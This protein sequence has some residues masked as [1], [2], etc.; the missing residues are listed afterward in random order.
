MK[1]DLKMEIMLNFLDD[2]RNSVSEKLTISNSQIVYLEHTQNTQLMF[3]YI[4]VNFNIGKSEHKL[5]TYISPEF[6]TAKIIYKHQNTIKSYDCFVISFI[7]TTK[8]DDELYDTNQLTYDIKAKMIGFDPNKLRLFMKDEDDYNSSYSDNSLHLL[9]KVFKN[10]E[11]DFHKDITT[12][13]YMIWKRIAQNDIQFIDYIRKRMDVV[14]PVI[15]FK[16]KELN[17]AMIDSIFIADFNKLLNLKNINDNNSITLKYDKVAVSNM[18][19][20]YDIDKTK[21]KPLISFNKDTLGYEDKIKITTSDS[22]RLNIY[23]AGTFDKF[24]LR[25][26]TNY[27]NISQTIKLSGDIVNT[28]IDLFDYKKLELCN[29][30]KIDDDVYIITQ[31]YYKYVQKISKPVV[32]LKV[33]KI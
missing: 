14:N 18:V 22:D 16:K 32:A 2:N 29:Y 21:E 17:D 9:K 12:D 8:G 24:H 25:K 27:T 7:G 19:K 30:I 26:T 4:T 6:V 33:Y 11:V 5:L 31:I 10:Y 23:N 20:N 3:P 15:I 1:D 28:N 13:D